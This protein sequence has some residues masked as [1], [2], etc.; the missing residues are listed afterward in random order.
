MGRIMYGRGVMARASFCLALALGG[1]GCSATTELLAPLK[2]LT[3]GQPETHSVVLRDTVRMALPAE[4]C[5]DS[6]V[7]NLGAGFA[8]VAGCKRI[9][10]ETAAMP[11]VIATVQVGPAGSQV[12][13]AD[14]QEMLAT[15]HGRALLSTQ[16]DADDV[17]VTEATRRGAVVQAVYTDSGSAGAEQ[18][19]RSFS[20]INGSLVTVSVRSLPGAG[21]SDAQAAETLT[22]IVGALR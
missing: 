3:L 19:W 15:P 4:W 10:R 7:S 22:Q 2:N 17:E 11:P 21:A 16:G 18:I 5:V 14:L 9:A 20:N 8:V 6:Q 1:A 13:M 12:P